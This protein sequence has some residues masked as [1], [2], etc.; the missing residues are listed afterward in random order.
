MRSRSLPKA[1]VQ[2]LNGVR[3]IDFTFQG[4][5]AYAS[6]LLASLGAEVVKIESSRRPDP[7]RGR[8]NRPYLRSLLF[9]DVNGGKK[10]LTLDMKT[11]GGR[12]TALRLIARSDAVIDNFRPGVMK[13]WGMDYATL[14]ASDERLVCASLSAVGSGG[15][16]SKL[17]GYAGI[18]NALGGLGHLTGYR[19]GPPTELRT[20]VDMRVGAFFAVGIMQGLLAARLTGCGTHIDCSAAECV[21]ALCGESLAAFLLCDESVGRVGNEHPVFSPHGNFVCRDEQWVAVAIRDEQDWAA[22]LTLLPG[23]TEW[24]ADAAARPGF[25]QEHADSATALLERWLVETPSEAAVAELQRCG[26]PAA[27]V[28]DAA[29]LSAD[30]QLASRGFFVTLEAG[31][32]EDTPKK[33]VAASPWR[34]NGARPDVEPG[35]TLGAD[36]EAILRDVLG[37]SNDEVTSLADSGALL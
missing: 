8:E 25:R 3:I 4:A 30:P 29:G 1:N 12:E 32:A 24:G 6:M 2:V 31:D 23:G 11:E 13:S 34:V 35:P 20:S 21:A 7:T 5:G 37:M 36:T 28:Q 15:P 27:Q 16:L 9:D 14:A 19:D 26:I 22:F 10:S 33:V 17:P 18:F